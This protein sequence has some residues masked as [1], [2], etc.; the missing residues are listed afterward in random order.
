MGRVNIEINFFIKDRDKYI[1]ITEEQTQYIH[2]TEDITGL[3]MEAGFENIEIFDDYNDEVYPAKSLRAV[4][5][6]V[7]L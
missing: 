4:F 5:R 6:A 2:E 7:K 3:L 1:M